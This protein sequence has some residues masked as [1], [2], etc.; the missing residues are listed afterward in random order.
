MNLTWFNENSSFSPGRL[1]FIIYTG[2]IL[3]LSNNYVLFTRTLP[4]DTLNTY[5]LLQEDAVIASD[6]IPVV[7]DFFLENMT[8]LENN[9]H[10]A[11]IEFLLQ[12]NEPNP[13]D[14]ITTIKYYLP[15]KSNVSLSIYNMVGLKV[16]NLVNEYQ[17]SGAYSYDFNAIDLNEG[18]Y[19][20][21]IKAGEFTAIKKMML[22][23]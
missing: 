22:L 10:H 20:I 4:E 9:A 1:D 5:N 14:R 12:Q 23:R 17:N 6:H 18:M 11:S 7:S 3:A 21:K 13:F 8:G 2:S 16:A 19:F 15:K